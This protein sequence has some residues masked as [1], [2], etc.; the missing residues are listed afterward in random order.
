MYAVE[1]FEKNG[2][3][4]GRI[5]DII[6]SVEFMVFVVVWEQL[7]QDTHIGQA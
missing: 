6:F 5:A 7:C 1:D 3:A 2:Y 4:P